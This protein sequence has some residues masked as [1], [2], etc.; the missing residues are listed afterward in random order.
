MDGQKVDISV[1][2]VGEKWA[3]HM[4]GIWSLLPPT[5]ELSG[6]WGVNEEGKTRINAYR[7]F[8]TASLCHSHVFEAMSSY[9]F[10]TS[11]VPIALKRVFNAYGI[12]SG[13]DEILRFDSTKV[14]EFVS[15]CTMEMQTMTFQP[16]LR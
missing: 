16:F 3:W 5:P 12:P 1:D 14:D 8:A 9:D 2:E 11:R 7:K 4:V 13:E 10:D 6:A 15:K